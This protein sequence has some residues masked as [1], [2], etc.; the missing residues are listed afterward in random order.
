MDMKP[1]KQS[2]DMKS[3]VQNI[4]TQQKILLINYLHIGANFL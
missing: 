1:T 2:A 3:I 4:N